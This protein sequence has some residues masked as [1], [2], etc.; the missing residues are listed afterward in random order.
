ML[1][2]YMKKIKSVILLS[3]TIIFTVVLMSGCSKKDNSTTSVDTSSNISTEQ[4]T[5]KDSLASKKITSGAKQND[6]DS[7]GDA[8][9]DIPNAHPINY[10][11]F[12][13]ML[14]S[15]TDNMDVYVLR[16]EPGDIVDIEVTPSKGLDVAVIT[17]G[18]KNKVTHNNAFKGEAE[19]VRVVKDISDE[20]K[21]YGIGIGFATIPEYNDKGRKETYTL[22]VT[23]VKQ[24]D[25]G[26]GQDASSNWDNPTQLKV[27]QY[28]GNMLLGADKND[29][30]GISLE[31]GQKV[32][33]TV[34]PED[35]LDVAVGIANS[36]E[37]NFTD[38]FQY[39]KG[40]KGDT[41]TFVLEARKA[42]IV[43]FNV[44]RVGKTFGKYSIDV[45]IE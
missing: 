12:E 6:A 33:I 8:G 25:G 36:A 2:K 34:S 1:K 44:G 20:N 15:E 10:G 38:N 26:S 45:K 22:K 17:V 16:Y 32:N 29:D 28:K 7:G 13:G 21:K 11:E 39:N 5:K 4:S 27:G 43:K 18:N 14:V 23:Q 31:S 40:F 41:E 3:V 42:G 37:I 24:N 19:T 30:Y 35:E 9:K